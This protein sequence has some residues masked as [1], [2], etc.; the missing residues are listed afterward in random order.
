M[1]LKVTIAILEIFQRFPN[2]NYHSLSKTCAT[3]C[4]ALSGLS[5]QSDH[6]C[7]LCT[8]LKRG[9]PKIGIAVVVPFML[10]NY[11]ESNPDDTRIAIY[12]LPNLRSISY[13]SSNCLWWQC[14]LLTYPKEVD[15]LFM[16]DCGL[17]TYLELS[18]IRER[19]KEKHITWRYDLYDKYSNHSSSLKMN[20]NII[21][22]FQLAN[23]ANCMMQVVG[24]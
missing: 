11:N 8:S 12:H 1:M 6:S 4:D 2:W 21:Q 5:S 18:V 14:M 9:K 24:I 19:K 10:A 16:Y 22:K 23:D 17:L 13:D 20:K 15:D 3:G 7:N